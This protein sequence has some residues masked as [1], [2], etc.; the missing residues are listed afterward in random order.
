MLFMFYEGDKSERNDS[1]KLQQ[2]VGQVLRTSYS[3]F[4]LK[5]IYSIYNL[6][7]I[8]RVLTRNPRNYVSCPVFGKIR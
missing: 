8:T 2:Y 1:T 5:K 6:H 4:L 3:V 7:I